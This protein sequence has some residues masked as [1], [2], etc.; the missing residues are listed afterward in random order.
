MIRRR[1]VGLLAHA[2]KYIGYQVMWQWIS[3]IA[4]MGAVFNIAGLLEN[5]WNGG[6]MPDNKDGG[7]A[8]PLYG[9]AVPL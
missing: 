2:K 7:G 6:R 4:Q 9:S 1:L 8:D 5:V 3:L